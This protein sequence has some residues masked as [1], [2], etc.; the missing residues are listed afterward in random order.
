M[1]NR[2]RD[3]LPVCKIRKINIVQKKFDWNLM[4]YFSWKVKYKI[5]RAWKVS[6]FMSILAIRG[7]F[8]FIFFFITKVIHVHCKILEN[9]WTWND[10]KV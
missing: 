4:S 9:I 7:I 1:G 6:I 8:W 2:K 10:I 5:P 3:T